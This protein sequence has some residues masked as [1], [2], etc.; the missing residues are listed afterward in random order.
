MLEV[1]DNWFKLAPGW[2]FVVVIFGGMFVC[3]ILGRKLRERHDR[4]KN[5]KK[6]SEEEK[7][8]QSFLVSSV[9][10]LLAL[11]IGFTFSM[12]VDRFDSRRV[13]VLE[14]ANAITTTYLRSQLLEEPH[15]T[16]LSGLL[17]EYTDAR[18]KLAVAHPGPAQKPLLEESDRLISELWKATVAAFPTIR[19]Y[20]FSSAYLETMN[21]L[22]D[23]DAAR[24]ASRMARVPSE[25]FLVLLLYQF[26]ATAVTSYM[27]V[28][29]RGRTTA[30]FLFVL[31]GVALLL[32]I[33]IDRPT[34]GGIT[35]S[36]RP[37]TQL[38][39][40]MKEHPPAWFGSP[41]SAQALIPAPAR[42]AP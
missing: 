14:E 33:D 21:A 39:D 41:A 23:L 10:G 28:G 36:Q 15:R 42:R 19:P 11:L 7:N 6:D 38:R 3:L 25:V 12:A 18:I 5:S 27:L 40:F 8:Q 16:R 29:N 37:M 17:A 31:F 35:E 34:S 4:R 2:A 26:T 13:Y 20:D 22:I 9:M 32:V 24:K 30:I 1:F